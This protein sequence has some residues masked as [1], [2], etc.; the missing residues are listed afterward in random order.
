MTGVSL[1]RATPVSPPVDASLQGEYRSHGADTEFN[2]AEYAL[3]LRDVH[4][5]LGKLQVLDGVTFAVRRGEFMSLVGPS[6]AGKSTIL[7][8]IAGFVPADSGAVFLDGL[9]VARQPAHRRNL[10]FIFQ[11]HALFPHLSVERNIR[12]P[13]DMRHVGRKAANLQVGAALEMVGLTQ[14]ASRSPRTLSGGQRQRV[15]IARALVFRPTVLLMDEPLSSLDR[16]LRE[17]LSVEIRRIQQEANVTVLYVTHD[18]TEALALSD[19]VGSVGDGKILQ[20]GTPVDVHDRPIS[21]YVARLVGPINLASAEVVEA[22]ADGGEITVRLGQSIVKAPLRTSLKQGQRI[23]VGVRPYAIALNDAPTDDAS[24]NCLEG[25]LLGSALTGAGIQH[26]LELG[27]E[28][29][30]TATSAD[31]RV[32]R[33]IGDSIYASWSVSDTLIFEE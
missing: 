1:S 2:A 5:T 18:Q 7:N 9:D 17:E 29:P 25:H 19:R 12:F 13:L 31:R 26:R 14:Y 8:V 24:T 6:G 33:T 22:G 28:K 20:I 16:N 15:A 3:V 10:G 30:W 32:G 4:K 23:T 11:D 21:T 27:A